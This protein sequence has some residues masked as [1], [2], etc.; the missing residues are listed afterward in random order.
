MDVD[1]K[2]SVQHA[3][4]T[5]PRY[6]ER[7]VVAD[8]KPS[9]QYAHPT[10][11]PLVDA[12]FKPNVQ[13]ARPTPFRYNVVSHDKSI[14][15]SCPPGT[16]R[17][18]KD[19]K[20]YGVV[21]GRPVWMHV[22]CKP[23]ATTVPEASVN[24]DAKPQGENTIKSAADR[25]QIISKFL[26]PTPSKEQLLKIKNFTSTFLCDGPCKG[27]KNIKDFYLCTKCHAWQHKPCR[28]HGE[29]GDGRNPVCNRCYTSFLAHYENI[30]E[31]VHAQQRQTAIKAWQFIK[32]PNNAHD[33]G[34][35][36]RCREIVKGFLKKVF[37]WQYRLE[38]KYTPL[39]LLQNEGLFLKFVA[40]RRRQQALA[41]KQKSHDGD[42]L[43]HPHNTPNSLITKSDLKR[44]RKKHSRRKKNRGKFAD[45]GIKVE[46]V[47][48][49]SMDSDGDML[50][51]RP[52]A[53]RIRKGGKQ[54]KH[55]A[56]K[57]KRSPTR[58]AT[59]KSLAPPPGSDDDSDDRSGD[60]LRRR[61]PGMQSFG[62]ELKDYKTACRCPG[63]PPNP[64]DCYQCNLCPLNQ[65]TLCADDDKEI[66]EL[67]NL[68]VN[69]DPQPEPAVPVNPIQPRGKGRQH[70]RP[71]PRNMDSNITKS[72]AVPSSN[73]AFPSSPPVAPPPPTSSQPMMD[74][75][76]YI[77]AMRGEVLQLCHTVL[78]EEYR[79]M[80]D[81][82]DDEEGLEPIVAKEPLP[83][84]PPTAWVDEMSTRMLALFQAA[85]QAETSK[86]MTPVLAAFPRQQQ[87]ILKAL[88][89]LTA[90]QLRYGALKG[91]RKQMGVLL[92][93]V[94]LEEKG[95]M[96]KGT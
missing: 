89:D 62:G 20:L 54:E 33:S 14:K 61:K 67:C 63:P 65:H 35:L 76:A 12:D 91:K 24:V 18:S 41:D 16:T 51:S 73:V 72:F 90:D 96:W 66:P 19:I 3:Q 31:W 11:Q 78:W 53:G 5:Q 6:M 49:E 95:R 81:A 60:F 8:A 64:Q 17:L 84:T 9:I 7:F 47:T 10:P 22:L 13:H 15:C 69:R 86:H 70:A 46:D 55:P 45:T 79:Q 85:G 58:K 21:D 52:R 40:H 37:I 28:L 39:T 27:S 71:A 29:P 43:A 57:R 83:V 2:P 34:R 1:A 36:V 4:S 48:D 56:K 23:D 77:A 68:C 26:G 59:R 30:R 88:R 38:Y 94:G 75:E 87:S 92:E 82:E 80:P 42:P 74:P 44:L 93:V 50:T 32:D 25:Q